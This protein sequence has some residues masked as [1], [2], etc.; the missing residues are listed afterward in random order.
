MSELHDRL[1][2]ASISCIRHTMLMVEDMKNS[3]Y[4]KDNIFEKELKSAI[5]NH[6]D[7]KNESNFYFFYFLS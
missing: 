5:D 4:G 6:Q 3:I 1:M 2:C 7:F